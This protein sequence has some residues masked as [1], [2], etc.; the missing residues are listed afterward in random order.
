MLVASGV[1]ATTVVLVR[2]DV[3]WFLNDLLREARE[4]IVKDDDDFSVC[5]IV[6]DVDGRLN[7]SSRVED[8]GGGLKSFGAGGAPAII[9]VEGPD[10]D[11]ASSA[12]AVFV[13]FNLLA[14][15]ALA[16][17]EGSDVSPLSA[18]R[19]DSTDFDQLEGLI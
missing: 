15:K 1:A 12:S 5:R 8:L 4:S 2:V 10:M 9:G 19:N 3:V 11:S 16:S 14:P 6:D 13:A 7:A 18:T 17:S